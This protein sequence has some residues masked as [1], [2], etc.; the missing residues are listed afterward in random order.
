M[1]RGGRSGNPKLSVLWILD[2]PQA[3]RIVSRALSINGGN[4]VKAA[5]ALKVG[6]STLKRWISEHNEL[7]NVARK[8]R[9]DK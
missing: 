4:A 7:A 6:Y 5:K 9:N 8:A 3:I 1:K 2:E